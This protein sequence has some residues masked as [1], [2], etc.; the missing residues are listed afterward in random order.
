M[1]CIVCRHRSYWIGIDKNGDPRIKQSE[2][3]VRL[4]LE[5]ALKRDIRVIPVLM[6]EAK[7]PPPEKLPESLYP[8][9][10][11]QTYEIS[12]KRWKYDTDQLIKFLTQLGFQLKQ[13]DIPVPQKSEGIS[14]WLMYGLIGLGVLVMAGLLFE[15]FKDKGAVKTDIENHINEKDLIKERENDKT[16]NN[17]IIKPEPAPIEQEKIAPVQVNVSGAWYDAT[18]Q[19]IMYIN[20]TGSTLELKSVSGAGVT[21]GE[22]VGTVDGD[23]MTF[24]VQLYNVGVISGSAT[25]VANSKALNGKFIIN[26]NGA[27]YTEDFYWTKQ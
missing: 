18:N 4:E 16:D 3:W 13:Q 14:K 24:K 12:N 23:K 7:L 15:A 5:T 22:G 1:R 8:L 21:T 6:R 19:Y 20:Q 10:N 9:L 2:D 17:L 26:S 11:R 27:S 25:V